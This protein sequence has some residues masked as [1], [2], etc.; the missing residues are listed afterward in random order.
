MLL[1][2]ASVAAF[3]TGQNNVII[4]AVSSLRN[5]FANNNLPN[6]YYEKEGE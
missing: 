6:E 5:H 1:C 3:V 4:S 2:F